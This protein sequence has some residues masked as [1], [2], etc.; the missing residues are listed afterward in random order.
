VLD[1]GR[2]DLDPPS[3]G[4]VQAAEL[5]LLLDAA[6]ADR[7]GAVDQLSFRGVAPAGLGVAALGLDARQR[8]ER[9]DERDVEDVLD[10]M[11]DDSAQ[12]VVRV[13]DIRAAVGGDVIEHAGR[14][15]VEHVRER[16]L[17]QVMGTGLDVDH[18]VV[19]LDEHLARQA[20][21]V[22]ARVRGALE[23][24]LGERRHH[25]ADVHVHAPAVSGTRLQQR[26]RVQ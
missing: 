2:H 15:R 24:R 5:L 14:E 10:A 13:H 4:A 19:R 6:D 7:V 1:A 18:R 3:G 16:L 11:G 23:P 20:D 22:T 17:R 8:V 26:R 21:V 12:P 9:G 25:L